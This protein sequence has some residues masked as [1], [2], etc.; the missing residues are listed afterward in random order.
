MAS[1]QVEFSRLLRWW[2][3]GEPGERVAAAHALF[4]DVIDPDTDPA[5]LSVRLHEANA[6]FRCVPGLIAELD[7]PVG[8]EAASL[9]RGLG[10]RAVEPL[11]RA[12][13]GTLDAPVCAGLRARLADV[14]ADIGGYLAFDEVDGARI[15]RLVRIWQARE[16]PVPLGAVDRW[17]AVQTTDTAAVL[18]A[19]ELSDPTPVTMPVATLSRWHTWPRAVADPPCGSDCPSRGDEGVC[20]HVDGVVSH[21]PDRC[22]YTYVSPALDGWTLVVG[23]YPPSHRP[24]WSWWDML[25][26][27]LL[28]DDAAYRAWVIDRCRDLSVRFGAAQWYST[29]VGNLWC[30]AFDGEI[31]HYH[32]EHDE[33]AEVGTSPLR[34][35]LDMYDVASAAAELSVDPGSIDTT[36]PFTGTGAFA[37]TACGRRHGVPDLFRLAR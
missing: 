33:E 32:D 21:L 25:T 7:G 5:D 31:V 24:D 1:G 8:V 12:R 35:P 17:F 27:S 3:W 28:P 15:D 19:F 16:R 36:F 13:R 37:R 29:T 2:R 9:L 20:G 4:P 30:V 26:R 10:Q 23:A 14:L 6:W 22:T 11:R 18:A 34:R